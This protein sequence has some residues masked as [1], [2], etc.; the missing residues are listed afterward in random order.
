MWSRLPDDWRHRSFC[1]TISRSRTNS[2][3]FVQRFRSGWGRLDFLF[4]AISSVPLAD[5][6]GRLIDSLI[7]GFTKV[8]TVSLDSLIPMARLAEAL[9]T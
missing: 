1:P 7:E 6:H 3:P 4:H 9:M 8:D 2:N 5:L